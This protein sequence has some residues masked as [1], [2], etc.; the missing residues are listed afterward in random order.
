M[1]DIETLRVDGVVRK[2]T[3]GL[4][5][6]EP[7]SSACFRAR[8][9]SKN[10]VPQNSL[11]CRWRSPACAVA[12]SCL[13]DE[14]VGSYGNLT[15]GFSPREISFEISLLGAEISLF[16]R[17]LAKFVSL[18]SHVGR[19]S[20][21]ARWCAQR[22]RSVPL[23]KDRRRRERDSQ[24]RAAC[25]AATRRASSRSTTRPQPAQVIGWSLS[26]S[27][28]LSRCAGGLSR[29]SRAPR[30]SNFD[31]AGRWGKAKRAWALTA[32][33]TSSLSRTR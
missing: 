15:R 1:A 16:P 30:A 11:E 21:L 9:R 4:I 25:F 3:R 2:A 12:A 22:L 18:S 20:R 8:P 32:Y 31:D 24:R 10:R 33:S 28:S 5:V 19:E 7:A 6:F 23:S 27:L 26:F 29:E 14:E 13:A 17:K